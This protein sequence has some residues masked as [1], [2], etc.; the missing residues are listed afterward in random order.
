MERAC[1][2]AGC[3]LILSLGFNDG[4]SVDGVL[5]NC[6]CALRLEFNSWCLCRGLITYA[7][8][9]QLRHIATGGSVTRKSSYRG[10]TCGIDGLN[11]MKRRVP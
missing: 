9:Q 8:Y 11:G 10:S 1:G 6:G 4:Y 3:L 5:Y 7:I 2:H